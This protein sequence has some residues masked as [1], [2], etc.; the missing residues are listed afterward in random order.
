LTS[1]GCFPQERQLSGVG[2]QLV[3]SLSGFI[4]PRP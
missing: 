1:K 3:C 2:L 4:R